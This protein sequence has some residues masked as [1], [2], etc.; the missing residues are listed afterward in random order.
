MGKFIELDNSDVVKYE[1]LVDKP[2]GKVFA[3]EKI[4]KFYKFQPFGPVRSSEIFYDTPNDLLFKAGIILSKIQEDNRV[5][6]KVCQNSQVKT[7]KTSQKV[8]SHKVGVKDTLKD[9][10]FYLV[11]GIRGLFATPIYIDLEN[12][13]KNAV[14]KVA[15]FTDA[16]VYKVISGSGFRAF[17]CMEETRYENYE[18]KRQSKVQGM[19]VKLAGPEQYMPEFISFNNAI[20][21]HCKDFI[22]VHDN[23]YEHVKKV[24]RKIDP[25]QLKEDI[26]KAKEKYSNKAE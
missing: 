23:I 15:T 18:T 7:V 1:A 3:L 26:K 19:T 21:K 4:L 10:S 2:F 17:M 14:P 5:F 8:F 13:I 11:D 22:E 12:V 24:T 16:T 20:K 25:K 6:F 9:H